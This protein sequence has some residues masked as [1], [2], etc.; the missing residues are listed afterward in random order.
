VLEQPEKSDDA[1]W[2]AHFE[3]LKRWQTTMPDSP[4]PRIALGDAY[5][6]YAWDARGTGYADTITEQ[7]AEL[8]KTRAKKA[9]DYFEEA[10]KLKPA[11]PDPYVGMMEVLDLLGGSLD[12]HYATFRAGIKIAPRHIPLYTELAHALLPKWFGEPGDVAKYAEKLRKEIGGELGDEVYFRMA[13]DYLKDYGGDRQFFA[14]TGFKY[15]TLRPGILIALRDYPENARLY[16]CCCYLAC[17]ADDKEL[18]RRLLPRL[19]T[20]TF[21]PTCWH[22]LAPLEYFRERFYPLCHAD[23]IARTI[24]PHVG[25]VTSVTCLH[26]GTLLVG[27]EWPLLERFDI[28]SG[29]WLAQLFFRNQ[30]GRLAVDDSD[31]YMV[32]SH[33]QAQNA[34]A[35]AFVHDL[36]D[37]K[38][39][40]KPLEGHSAGV[41]G[42][43]V[44]RDGK[45]CVTVSRD[46]TARLWNLTDASEPLVLK[47][48]SPLFDAAFAYNGETLF[49]TSENGGLWQWDAASGKRRGG[50]LTVANHGQ[51][52]CRVC[53]FPKSD[54]LVTA[55]LDGTVRRWDIGSR[56]FAESKPGGNEILSVA[57]SPD[58]KW[59]AVG[60]LYGEVDV[61]WANSL[62]VVRRYKEHCG[63]V[64]GLS[65]SAD[66]QTLAS[67]ALDS[68]VKLWP[69]GR[70]QGSTVKQAADG[71]IRL[72]A[73]DARIIDSHLIVEGGR[74]ENLGHWDNVNDRPAWTV[75]V[76]KAG[77]YT[78]E[79]IY[80]ASPGNGGSQVELVC[81]NAKSPGSVVQTEGWYDYQS[82]TL[83]PLEL[84][85]GTATVTLA[86]MKK[87]GGFV[88]NL[89]GINLT[90]VHP[91][92]K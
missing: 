80:S 43:A 42:V 81:G 30:V 6:H 92:P 52:Y 18:A 70:L 59:I 82:L 15:E 88:M 53:C 58:E 73:G 86:A 61:L 4:T 64:A 49:T 33:G 13:A 39:P 67:G 31:R 65:F 16:N 28:V 45:R 20:A 44:T 11:D 68:A 26:D 23:K 71:S 56:K 62:Q 37:A 14:R 54:R 12:E 74:V 17:K 50:P 32:I 46:K 7:G 29:N 3:R 87:A 5:V 91:V 84:K 89:R 36:K 9:N 63:A 21:E 34:D 48:P 19:D 76:A 90:P 38:E 1:A 69:V 79:L 2:K 22:G 25:V 85:V 41:T 47:H 75:E 57:V 77:A 35:V 66:S 24:A 10:L 60:R 8:M 83:S 72:A 78:P 27:G 55:S 51:W 40:P